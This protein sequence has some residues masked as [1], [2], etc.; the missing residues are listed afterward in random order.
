MSPKSKNTIMPEFKSM[1]YSAVFMLLSLLLLGACSGGSS[2]GEDAGTSTVECDGS[3]ADTPTRLTVA[4]VET[5]LAQA[6]AEAQAQGEQATIA[7]ADRVGNVLAVYRMGAA[8]DR[9]VLIASA[10]NGAGNA[11][12]D[13]GLE[14]ISLPATGLALNID[15][16]AAISKA[17]TGAYLS[18]EGNAFSS[19]TASQIVQENFN[20][21][22]MNQPAGPLFGVQFSQL[23]CSDFTVDNVNISHGPKRAP[24]GLSADPG[25]L[26]LYKNGTPVGGIGVIADGLYSIDKVISDSDRSVDEMIAY[27]G[28]YQY[29]APVD[30]RGDRIT[31][32]GKTF[33]FS[34]VDFSDLN[35][36]PAAA[37]SYASIAGS[38]GSLISVTGYSNGTIRA[39]LAFGQ[40]ESGIRRD[41]NGFPAATDAFIFV[42]PGTN[43][44]RYPAI[45]APDGLLTAAQVQVILEEALTVA[46]RA[47]AQIRRP[48]GSQARVTIT[49]VDTQGEILGMVR[50]RD[51]PVFGSDVSVQK[52]RTAAFFSSAD[53][54][55]FL[56]TQPNAS[57]F[58]VSSTGLPLV[59]RESVAL[60]DYV[61]AVQNFI[62]DALALTDGA[63]AFSD[64]AGGNL[65]RPTYPDGLQGRPH[66]PF[67]KAPGSW[68]VFSTGLQLDMVYNAIIQHVLSVATGGGVADITS[69]CS[70]IDFDPATLSFTATGTTNQMANGSQIFPGSVPIYS[71]STLVGGIGVSGDGVDQDD[72]ISFLGVHNAGQRLSGAINN[73]P[74]AMRADNLTPQGVRL[75]FVQ[76]PQA[77]FL[78]SDA[79]NVCA[80]K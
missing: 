50:T 67:S 39:G 66:G 58:D 3:C 52:A 79:D 28:T 36:D 29:A 62:P 14:G 53:A 69:R 1:H 21:G 41:S 32:D 2:T 35:T 70:G 55:N 42:D 61:T 7:V 59:L 78:D 27:A 5:I 4:D 54:A 43:V 47:R 18:S 26:P 38:V 33:R 71:G 56:T 46:N 13:S 48:L 34:D 49:V 25:G 44:N 19:R 65:S 63:V 75:R 11:V 12:I 6:I 73:A 16:Q 17:I 31:A 22:E 10:T 80:G 68:S 72:M 40:R 77:P 60:G 8:A 45:N 37:N 24:L 30:R 9:G 74:R 23:S 76:C 64:R 15:D 51:A 57:Y 20:P